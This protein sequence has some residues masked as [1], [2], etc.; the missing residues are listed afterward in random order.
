MTGDLNAPLV[1]RMD[2]QDVGDYLDE[3]NNAPETAEQS[4]DVED[5]GAAVLD[6][7]QALGVTEPPS[8][9]AHYLLDQHPELAPD[10]EDDVQEKLVVRGVYPPSATDQ[11]HRTRPVLELN[12]RVKILSLRASQLAKGARAFIEIPEHLVT[13]YDI[14]EAELLAKRLPY[15][16]KRPIPNGQYEYWRLADLMIL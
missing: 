7:A 3:L 8:R 11:N 13:P 15:I 12:E 14:A 4:A 2:E 10:Y 6:T 9:Q 1:D 5:T 16:I